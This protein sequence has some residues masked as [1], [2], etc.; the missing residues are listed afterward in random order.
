M[1]FSFSLESPSPLAFTGVSVY[2]L[3][4]IFLYSSSN[5]A[6]LLLILWSLTEATAPSL[7]ASINP[8]SWCGEE[9]RMKVVVVEIDNLAEWKMRTKT[10]SVKEKIYNWLIYFK[11]IQFPFGIFASDPISPLKLLLLERLRERI[12]S[13]YSKLSC[14]FQFG[15][16]LTWSY[17]I[18]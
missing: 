14:F 13:M 10:G 6:T 2:F 18:Y 7:R 9:G 12:E 1:S 5:V 4:S 17:T 8:L 11:I 3:Y 16:Y 15:C